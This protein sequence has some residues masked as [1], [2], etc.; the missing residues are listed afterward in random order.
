MKVSHL[1]ESYPRRWNLEPIQAEILET[2]RHA[3]HTIYLE[4]NARRDRW[5]W[6]EARG[7]IVTPKLVYK[8]LREPDR[9]ETTMT[10]GERNPQNE[11][12]WRDLWKSCSTLKVKSFLW[13]EG[14]RAIPV[15]KALTR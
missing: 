5:I 12:P 2:E 15:F 4:R 8:K 11:P 7:G 13:Q 1:I 6:P 9:E 14:H 10:S 3:I